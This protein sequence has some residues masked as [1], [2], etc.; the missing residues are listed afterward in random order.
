MP[1]HASRTPLRPYKRFHVKQASTISIKLMKTMHGFE[2]FRAPQL[3][4]LL[5]VT[6]PQRSSIGHHAGSENSHIWKA[7]MSTSL[8]VIRYSDRD[9]D[10]PAVSA[11]IR[12]SWSGSLFGNRLPNSK[13]LNSIHH[14]SL[15]RRPA[16]VTLEH[17]RGTE[18]LLPLSGFK[19][20]QEEKPPGRIV[21]LKH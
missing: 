2:R 13:R 14:Y 21:L 12:R 18:A 4:E 1:L 8:P 17:S 6:V 10:T 9:C 15:R 20:L 16:E 7:P 3:L 5:Y 11:E 19:P